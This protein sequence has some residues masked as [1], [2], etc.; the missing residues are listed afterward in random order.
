LSSTEFGAIGISIDISADTKNRAGE[1]LC[2]LRGFTE[3]TADDRRSGGRLM[4]FL[5]VT[6]KND[7][8]I[9]IKGEASC[10]TE[11]SGGQ[12]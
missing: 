5:G 11:P 4:S 1:P 10:C 12:P 7:E 2:R 6:R 3:P 9:E 8:T